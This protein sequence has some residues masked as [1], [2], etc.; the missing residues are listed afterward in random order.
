MLL[1]LVPS[2]TDKLL[3]FLQ[4]T[5]S[6]C[7]IQFPPHMWISLILYNH[8]LSYPTPLYF[9]VLSNVLQKDVCQETKPR[10]FPYI[11]PDVHLRQG[12]Q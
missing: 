7:M 9:E 4:L 8:F 11:L 2:H 12:K 3:D 5:S 1:S 10:P 6:S